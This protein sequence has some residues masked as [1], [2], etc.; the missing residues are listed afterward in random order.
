MGLRFKREYLRA[1]LKTSSLYIM[2]DYVLK[3]QLLNISEG[4]I[5][6]DHLPSVPP[7]NA[8]PLMFSLIDFP[9]FSLLHPEVLLN[10]DIEQM[11]RKVIRMKAR[12]VRSFEGFS[13]VDKIF[14]TKI[15]CEFV[16]PGLL[17]KQLI[18]QYVSRYGKNLIYY[19]GLFEG[20]GQKSNKVDLVRKT[21]ELLGYDSTEQLARLRLKALHDYQSLESI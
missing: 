8:L 17:E 15:G 21:A 11:E 10:L 18:S 7:V 20:R 4:G 5:L 13:E 19:L 6:L 9:E 12:I 3:A 1:P 14:A 2:E 16:N